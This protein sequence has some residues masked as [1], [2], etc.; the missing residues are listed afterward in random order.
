MLS[1][2]IV[3]PNDYIV[4]G[5]D[6]VESGSLKLKEG[7]KLILFAW[8]WQRG[9]TL[10]VSLQFQKKSSDRATIIEFEDLHPNAVGAHWAAVPFE[11]LRNVAADYQDFGDLIAMVVTSL[12][13]K[14]TVG[15]KQEDGRVAVT[16]K[17]G[18]YVQ[19]SYI[20][21]EHAQAFLE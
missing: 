2:N 8:D 4:L 13:E 19:T 12:L 3:E 7:F 18:T 17:V 9:T 11:S 20:S 5:P 6:G 15:F 16:L 21:A 10:N 14:A 1:Y